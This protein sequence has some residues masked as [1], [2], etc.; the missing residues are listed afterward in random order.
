MMD[1]GKTKKILNENQRFDWIKSN[2]VSFCPYTYARTQEFLPTL[3]VAIKVGMEYVILKISFCA[4][5]F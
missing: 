2:F 3:W 1:Y 4:A 5:L